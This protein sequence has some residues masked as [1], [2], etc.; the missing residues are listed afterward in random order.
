[1]A[2]EARG[3]APRLPTLL[4]DTHEI[5]GEIGFTD[6]DIDGSSSDSSILGAF[7]AY[8]FRSGGILNPYISPKIVTFGGDLGDLFDWA[9]GVEGNYL[10]E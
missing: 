7:Y 4:T 5:G 6:V 2:A 1:M 9:Y 10:S 8:N 3:V